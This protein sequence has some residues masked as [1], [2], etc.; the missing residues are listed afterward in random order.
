MVSNESRPYRKKKRALQEQ[1]TRLRITEA[2][3]EL[4]RS[5][6]P[7]RTTIKEVAERAGVGRMTVYNHFPTDAELLEACTSHYMAG[8]PPPD[9][10][11]LAAVEDPGERIEVALRELF[12]WYRE[13][14]E[15]TANALRDSPLVPALDAVMRQRF[16]PL[17][18]GIVDV[19]AAGRGARGARRERLLAALRVAVDF[20]TW[21]TLVHAG[22]DDAA[23]ARLAG[24]FVEAAELA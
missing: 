8:H 2:A 4:H 22:L 5:V 9:P 7:A 24:R 3:V 19:L 14:E 10:S 13:T 18:D 23:A 20:G 17:L 21:R 11:A 15:M 16:W 12:A 6:G 1:E